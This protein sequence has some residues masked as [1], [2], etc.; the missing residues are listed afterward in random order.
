VAGRQIEEGIAMKMTVDMPLVSRCTVSECA[1]NVDTAC[2]ARAITVGDGV[3]PG[4]DTFLG[5][6][7][8]TRDTDGNAGVGACKVIGCTHNDDYECTASKITVGHHGTAV[9][10]L[11]FHAR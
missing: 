6:S 3:H 8:H 11:S 4:C 7:R 5:S 2:H 10:C 9:D 1:Y